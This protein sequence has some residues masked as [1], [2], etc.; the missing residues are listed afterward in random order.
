MTTN[1]GLQPHSKMRGKYIFN[2]SKYLASI[3]FRRAEYHH[4]VAGAC[5][6]QNHPD[7]NIL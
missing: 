5:Q 1:V 4:F 2:R 6:E 3:W 7:S